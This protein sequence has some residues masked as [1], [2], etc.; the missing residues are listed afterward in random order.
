MP[1]ARMATRMRS[2]ARPRTYLPSETALTERLSAFVIST[3]LR[4]VMASNVMSDTVDQL[5]T[6]TR[7]YRR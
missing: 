2:P 5:V 7:G 4:V 6:A 3:I 1:S